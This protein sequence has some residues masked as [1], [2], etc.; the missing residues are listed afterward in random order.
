MLKKG[1]DY[2]I[3]AD[4]SILLF[5]GVNYTDFAS[6]FNLPQDSSYTEQWIGQRTE[7]LLAGIYLLPAP[8]ERMPNLIWEEN[9][10][11][12]SVSSVQI[13]NWSNNL[14]VP[15]AQTG[16]LEAESTT[17][18]DILNR[19]F[20]YDL[21]APNLYAINSLD[22]FFQYFWV[23]H[24]RDPE[25]YSRADG[26][27]FYY[28]EVE[29]V[30]KEN[31]LMRF[32]PMLGPTVMP[33][34]AVEQSENLLYEVSEQMSQWADVL[35]YAQAREEGLIDADYSQFNPNLMEENFYEQNGSVD[36]IHTSLMNAIM[37]IISNL[38]ATP[39]KD[40]SGF[41]EFW[42]LENIG[43]L[44]DLYTHFEREFGEN[45]P[46]GQLLSFSQ[47]FSDDFLQRSGY[48]NP[49]SYDEFL[50]YG[51]RSSTGIP[52]SISTINELNQDY[53][54]AIA[55][56]MLRTLIYDPTWDP[57]KE[58]ADLATLQNEINKMVTS[59]VGV[60]ISWVKKG[61]QDYHDI[62][63][64]M[65][66]WRLKM[67]PYIV[68]ID[69]EAQRRRT[70]G[71]TLEPWWWLAELVGS[72]LFE[73]ID[74]LLTARDLLK[75]D[76]IALIGLLPLIPNAL[77]KIGRGVESIAMRRFLAPGSPL[78]NLHNKIK[79]W[80]EHIKDLNQVANLV[81]EGA[82]ILGIK[83]LS[84]YI[85][86]VKYVRSDEYF[87][88]FSH[89]RILRI[90]NQT[91]L[92]NRTFQ[93]LTVLHEL[94]HAQVFPHI[95]QEYL[96]D[97]FKQGFLIYNQNEVYAESLALRRLIEY[98]G[99]DNIPLETIEHSVGYIND[100]LNLAASNIRM[101]GGNEIELDKLTKIE[102]NIGWSMDDLIANINYLNATGHINIR[103]PRI[104][105]TINIYNYE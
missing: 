40:I 97:A 8:V 50:T 16:R 29:R 72:I 75:G 36:D 57:E 84:T 35:Q 1:T 60:D 77:T 32:A 105:W 43:S 47:A 90:S 41:L 88:S 94:I 87:G 7:F 28:S 21:V 39:I 61:F 33:F 78:F 56:D 18:N 104:P 59:I 5:T 85:N 70:L 67:K 65:N 19:N 42:G 82:Q 80:F 15:I 102:G 79:S 58:T 66:N 74:W 26:E 71:E 63:N 48:L 23:A 92:K 86:R 93:L 24:G 83:N 27:S 81:S 31:L 54:D 30:L 11:R 53:E 49:Q 17:S 95:P 98:M 2:Q 10:G 22:D 44:S 76:W 14:S 101:L 96:D 89:T 91:L 45:Y 73:P 62:L 37:N 64:N 100:Y 38:S 51:D 9:A 20:S 55:L 99:I 46:I 4:G 52:D 25:N 12:Y 13:E 34:V 68:H 6:T 3:Q 69:R 103:L